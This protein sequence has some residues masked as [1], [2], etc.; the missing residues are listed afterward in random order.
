MKLANQLINGDSL[1]V[2][3]QIRIAPYSLVI[4]DLPYG[5]TDFAWDK[6]IKLYQFWRLINQ[7]TTPEAVVVCFGTQPFT[8]ELV[9]SNFKC[10]WGETIWEKNCPVGFLDA[11]RRPLRA[12][13]N[14][15]VFSKTGNYTFNPQK[16]PG[17]PYATKKRK[18]AVGTHYGDIQRVETSNPTGDRYPRSVVKFNN[19]H[20]NH[21]HPTQKNFYLIQDLILSYSN[22]G[23][24]VLDPFSGSSVTAFV[25]K[26]NDR[27][28]TCIEKN[29]DYFNRA[30]ESLKGNI[31]VY[32]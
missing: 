16:T 31:A 11:N 10:F 5:T 3:A 18:D 6:K 9:M 4:A 8:S 17:K 21:W 28:Y 32:C 14:V 23:E 26:N 27:K 1:E 2:M 12:H 15:L 13:E 19:R 24:W 20:P 30:S 29:P 22:P 7:I 25:C